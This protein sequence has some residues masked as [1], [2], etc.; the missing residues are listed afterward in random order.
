MS[1][2]TLNSKNITNGGTI[3]PNHY[4]NNGM[5]LF[6]LW[7][8]TKP[9]AHFRAIMLATA[10]RYLVR[11]P[12]KNGIEDL[13]KGIETLRRLH[14]YELLEAKRGNENDNK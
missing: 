12:N 9:Y 3:Q 10:E 11:Y 2:K 13:E 6:E 14:E 1:E 4:R 5:D 8:M 7:Y